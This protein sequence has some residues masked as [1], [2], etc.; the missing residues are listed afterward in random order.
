CGSGISAGAPAVATAGPSTNPKMIAAF[1]APSNRAC[2][3]SR[4]S[5]RGR[6]HIEALLP[7]AVHGVGGN[8]LNRAL[9]GGDEGEGDDR[10]RGERNVSV[11]IEDLAVTVGHGQLIDIA[12]RRVVTRQL[13]H[14]HAVEI[15][16]TDHQGRLYRLAGGGP[17]PELAAPL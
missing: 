7:T 13:I 1:A 16:M 3:L 10:I 15:G 14:L 11:E 4:G 17:L 8:D 12:R 9:S 5:I 2:I 6:G